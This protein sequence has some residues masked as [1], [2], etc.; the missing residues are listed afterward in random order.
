MSP[1]TVDR[2]ARFRLGIVGHGMWPS[3]YLIPG[4][5]Q[6]RDV[7]VVAVCGRDSARA[8]TFAAA[9]GIPHSYD[10]IE[11]MLA[12]ED[13]D[14]VIIATPPGQHEDAVRAVSGFRAAV[15]C[16][17]PLALDVESARR[18]RDLLV[19]RP[20]LT[21]F[22]LRWQPLFQE[23][24]ETIGSGVVGAVRHVRIRYLQSSAA[25]SARGWDWHFDATD[26]PLGVV[27]DLGPHAIDL[28]RWMVGDVT[29]V[30]AFARTTIAERVDPEGRRR[31]V[32]NHDDADVQLTAASGATVSLTI[33][34]VA[35]DIGVP[36]GITIEVLGAEGWI[37]M[38]SNE[39]DV[40]IG[41]ASGI[42][43]RPVP[44]M[45][46]TDGAGAQIRDF[47][48]SARGEPRAELPSIDDGYQAQCVMDAI[49]QSLSR[50]E[51]V[52]LT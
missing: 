20:A 5:R 52:T 31:Q 11:R 37:R 40:V 39:A 21:G 44:A 15:L 24:R 7:D 6:L 33:S 23:L 19:D 25:T 32:T 28:V 51:S 47:V 13:L 38:D 8:A 3:T 50:R 45:S 35:P 30:T 48:D 46:L 9:H 27:S 49:A 29:Q 17:K 43:R 34:R 1:A 2:D 14:G 36:G 4:A 10:S 42:H 41:T 16:E 22:T 12:V 26:E 18:I